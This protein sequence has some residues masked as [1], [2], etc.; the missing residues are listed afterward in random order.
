M[1]RRGSS[2]VGSQ[3]FCLILRHFGRLIHCKWIRGLRTSWSKFRSYTFTELAAGGD[4]ISFIHRQE[5]TSEF[6]CRIIVRQITRGLRFLHEKGIIHRDL[7]PENILLAYSPKIAY[8]RVMLADFGCCA[9]PKRSRLTTNT[10][11]FQYQA[12]YVIDSLVR[13]LTDVSQGKSPREIHKQ[14]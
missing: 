11:T 13:P 4:L 1:L 10:G 6:D 3:I 5:Y 14:L 7:K 2:N 8:Q 9:V 12:P